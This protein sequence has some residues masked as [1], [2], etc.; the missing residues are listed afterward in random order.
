M[1]RLNLRLMTSPWGGF[2]IILLL[3][4][5]LD[6]G[7]P[8][9]VWAQ[10]EERNPFERIERLISEDMSP[11]PYAYT[12]GSRR[13]PF[14]PLRSSHALDPSPRSLDK[15]SRPFQESMTLLGILFGKENSRAVVRLADGRRVM[16]TRGSRLPENSG[17]V[18]QITKDRVV[19]KHLENKKPVVEL[20]LKSSY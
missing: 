3:V 16:V 15:D 6:L 8:F 20:L 11:L 2:C 18:V 1:A 4:R 17:S 13:D 9:V 5:C 12:S 10:A 19:I 14:L 7:W